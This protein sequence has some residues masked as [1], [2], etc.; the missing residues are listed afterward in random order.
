MLQSGQK[1]LFTAKDAKDT[2]ENKAQTMSPGSRTWY[3]HPD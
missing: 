3:L 1:K 2:K